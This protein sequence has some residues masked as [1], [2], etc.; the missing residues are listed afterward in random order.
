MSSYRVNG[1]KEEGVNF[2]FDIT[3]CLAYAFTSVNEVLSSAFLTNSLPRNF[4]RG[5][6]RIVDLTNRS[7]HSP[8]QGAR[9]MLNFRIG[10]VWPNC[11]CKRAPALAA[12]NVLALSEYMNREP[13]L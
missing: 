3:K 1:G 12:V 5:D 7:Q 8:Y 11:E 10:A 4:L 9:G 13:L 2:L 6:L